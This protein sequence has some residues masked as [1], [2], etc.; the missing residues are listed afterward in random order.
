VCISILVLVQFFRNITSRTTAN[1]VRGVTLMILLG[2]A[3]FDA[4]SQNA[5]SP[6]AH[7]MLVG[8]SVLAIL[9]ASWLRLKVF[10]AAGA[11][12]FT[13]DMLTILYLSVSSQH[14]EDLGIALGVGFTIF[15]ALLLGGYILYRQNRE[16]L[17]DLWSSA[18]H[19]FAAWE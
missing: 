19:R 8:L 3:M 13:A 12:C 2:V 1:I 6:L 7:L 11:V 9:V 14:I 4:L 18:R 17:A 10:A 16:L 15:G 5:A